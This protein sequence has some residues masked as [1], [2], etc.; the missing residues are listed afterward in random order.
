MIT[1]YVTKLIALL[2]CMIIPIS[3]KAIESAPPPSEPNTINKP[4]ANNPSSAKIQDAGLDK[5]LS[6]TEI[7]ANI[8]KMIQP[9]ELKDIPDKNG[10]VTNINISINNHLSDDRESL[11]KKAYKA[12][13]VGQLE[14]AAVLYKK[15]LKLD[16]NDSYVLFALGTLYQRLKQYPDA[17][18]MYSRLL[19]VDPK[20]EKGINNYLMLIS[21]TSPSKALAQLQELE[22]ANANYSPVK[23]QIA[24]I[25]G[26][27]GEYNLA[28]TYLKKAI[29]LSP[30]LLNYRYN[31][32]I[33]YDK[34]GHYESASKLYKQVLDFAGDTIS[35]QDSLGIKSRIK[36]LKKE[37]Q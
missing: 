19:T 15:A 2:S 17:K 5:T 4:I 27:L 1:S 20:N 7:I 3:L 26:N 10:D 18:I 23:A 29:E 31:L 35:K 16:K 32:A 25:Y 34:M 21:E 37:F 36:F 12:F 30:E 28:E 13:Q 22:K 9:V 8:K 14:A 33:L 24:L 6:E 11:L